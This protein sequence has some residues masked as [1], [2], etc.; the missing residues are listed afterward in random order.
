MAEPV[1][2]SVIVVTKNPGII[3]DECLAALKDFA[4][5]IVVDSHSTDDTATLT[6]KHGAQYVSYTWNGQYPKKR[7]YCLESI[8]VAHEWIFFVDADEI[9]TPVMAAEIATTIKHTKHNAF[10]VQGK[11][12]FDGCILNHGRRN[13]KIVLFRRNHLC[14]PEYPDTQTPMGEI[15]G[16]YQPIVNGSVGQ[17]KMPLL[18]RCAESMDTWMERH[19]RYAQWQ[20]EME[21]NG[22]DF[23]ASE[24]GARKWMKKIFAFYP[25]R[26]AMAFIDSYILKCGFLDGCA[27]YKYASAR[28]WY[29]ARINAL[30]N[31][32]PSTAS[33]PFVSK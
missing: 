21:T 26:P 7:Q 22:A 1:P 24:T 23:S 3:L 9:V 25:L 19:S 29:Y 13:N 10:F 17:L 6:A 16:H 18:H 8:P 28:A 4:E 33:A 20:A 2:L 11:P 14:Y 31:A 30:R 5:I 32:I 27:G 12:V 15:E